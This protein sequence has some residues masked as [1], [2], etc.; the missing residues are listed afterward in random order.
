M[1]LEHTIKDRCDTWNRW[2]QIKRTRG[3]D[4]ILNLGLLAIF[5]LAATNIISIPLVAYAV[6]QYDSDGFT[7]FP[8]KSSDYMSGYRDGVIKADKHVQLMNYGKLNGINADQKDVKCP[9]DSFNADFCAG[10]KDGYSDEAMDQ[11]E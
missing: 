11:L 2:S 10:Y 5:S 4:N 9:P 8:T 6:S 7:I 3:A 1:K